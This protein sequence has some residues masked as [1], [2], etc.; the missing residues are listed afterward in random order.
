MQFLYENQG[1]NS[2]LVY[3]LSE[4]DKLDS[5]NYG[6]LANNKINNIIPALFSQV[7]TDEYLKYNISA[8]VTLKQYFEGVVNKKQIVNVFLS[9]TKAII[10]AQDYMIDTNMFVLNP[11]YIYVDVSTA[12]ASIICFPVVGYSSGV[13]IY[14]FFK[15]LMFTTSFDQTE[16][17]DYVAKIISFLNSNNNFSI[18]DFKK[19]L[20][21]IDSTVTAMPQQIPNP[22][23]VPIQQ[24]SIVNS[25][26]SSGQVVVPPTQ[27][28]PQQTASNPQPQQVAPVMS[29]TVQ[30]NYTNVSNKPITP[31]N[32]Q[33]LK[34]QQN[35]EKTEPKMSLMH[36]L[37]HFSKENLEIYKSQSNTAPSS[38]STS[39]QPNT[40]KKAKKEKPQAGNPVA[41]FNIPGVENTPQPKNSVQ[42][43]SN[44]KMTGVQISANPVQNVVQPKQTNQTIY[45]NQQVQYSQ[46]I[47]ND[48][49]IVNVA[50]PQTSLQMQQPVNNGF[51]GTSV[52]GVSGPL[53]T[54][55]LGSGAIG[56]PVI[57]NPRLIRSKNNETILINKPVFRI[58]KEKSYVDYFVS[59]N[60]A[61]SRSHA[62]IIIRDE[63]Y[64][65]ID[66]NSTNHTYINGN[67]IPSNTETPLNDK[68]M[69]KL[70]NEDFEFRIY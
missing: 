10:D 3:R 5:F 68:D 55:V 2:F 62:N 40:H 28:K 47:K 32:P 44:N 53:D 37:S 26:V 58:G 14:D 48:K 11:D 41:G 34:N 19:T 17:T 60:S 7:D 35:V 56:Q 49:P 63:E 51:G 27:S 70:G 9:I 31:S 18:L 4:D 38:G 30:G 16:N 22:N 59:D 67:M 39:S 50:M 57:K 61:V 66:T 45:N 25:N 15:N 46:P 36:L 43:Q 64:Y 33:N 24:K 21:S 69:L 29:N 54:T 52:L 65:V 6:M 42:P 12:E 13:K 8:K 20:I 1:S 23:P